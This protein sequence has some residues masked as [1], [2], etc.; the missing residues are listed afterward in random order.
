[1]SGASILSLCASVCMIRSLFWATD[2][3][4]P[5]F[6]SLVMLDRPVRLSCFI[7]FSPPHASTFS[8]LTH[9]F[10]LLSGLGASSFSFAYI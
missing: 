4:L 7:Y 8:L 5:A 10:E 9:H 3:R 1:M 2:S 6:P